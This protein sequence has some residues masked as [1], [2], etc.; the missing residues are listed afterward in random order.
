MTEPP[1]S[2]ASA[3]ELA[4]AQRDAL[5]DSLVRMV[6]LVRRE[7]GFMPHKDQQDLREAMARLAEA[8]RAV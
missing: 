2:L 8:G 3:L 5:A 7:A 6:R 1:D 4:L